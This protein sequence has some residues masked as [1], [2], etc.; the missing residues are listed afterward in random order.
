M[1]CTFSPLTIPE[2]L[3]IEP[4]V[5]QDTRCFFMETYKLSACASHGIQFCRKFAFSSVLGFGSH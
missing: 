3:L 5:F 1:G 4:D 2:V